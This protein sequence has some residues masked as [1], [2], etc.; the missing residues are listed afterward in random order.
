MSHPKSLLAPRRSA[1]VFA[2]PL[3]FLMSVAPAGAGESVTVDHLSFSTRGQSLWGPTQGQRTKGFD[4]PFFEE[5]VQGQRGS[6]Q[7]VDVDLDN[8]EAVEAWEQAMDRCRDTCVAGICPTQSQCINGASITYPCPTITNPFRTCTFSVTGI[9]PK[10]SGTIRRPFD[11]GAVV[12]WDAQFRW[13]LR[14]EVVIDEGSVDA[15]FETT[16][17]LRMPDKVEAGET[18]ALRIVPSASAR[19]ELTSRWPGVS[20]ALEAYADAFSNLRVRA[21]GPNTETG[22][23][24]DI[25]ED[26]YVGDS[27]GL[28]ELELAGFDVGPD[29]FFLRMLEQPLLSVD[30]GIEY[31]A[32]IPVYTDGGFTVELPILDVGLFTPALDTPVLG[33]FDG[34]F[35]NGSFDG[36][37]IRNS[38]APGPRD[39][40]DWGFVQE[41]VLDTDVARLDLDLDVLTAAAGM[42][43][44]AKA[45]VGPIVPGL[46]LLTVEGNILDV[47][48][49]FFLGFR[50]DLSFEPRLMVDLYFDPPALVETAPGSGTFDLVTVRRVLVEETVELQVV[51]PGGDLRIEPEYSLE[52][53]RFI[54]DTDLV[55]SPVI[56]GTI[57]QLKLGGLVFNVAGSAFGLPTNL[58]AIQLSGDISPP[59]KLADMNYLDES[60]QA[61]FSLGGFATLQGAALTVG[62]DPLFRRG[63]ANASGAVD[64]SDSVAILGRL[65][66]GAEELAC[67]DA[68]DANDDGRQD[69]SDP[70]LILGALF[71]GTG[72]IAAPGPATCG[73]DETPDLLGC[74]SYGTC[75]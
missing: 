48:A 58:A 25:T 34:Q 50:E 35:T 55:V 72:E 70:I 22:A 44:G 63:D 8:G 71:L 62:S 1:A 16:V 65:F 45:T 14:G 37:R 17:E 23:Q 21:A 68:A 32:G 61:V 11:A 59:V 60:S 39:L 24:M 75:S 64:I 46:A 53:N 20:A 29:G 41:G 12:E 27:D 15:E 40:F 66:L 2:A 49:A 57:I 7:R 36:A 3:A 74:A 9:G 54:N 10:P 33:E 19:A 38:I 26:I 18:F 51:H 28:F 69:I 31:N 42:P 52:E 30:E 67:D 6:I 73:S 56:Q 5:V 47:D 43:L 4:Y 13:G